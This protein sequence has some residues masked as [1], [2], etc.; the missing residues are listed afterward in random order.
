MKELLIFIATVFRDGF[1][2]ALR[3]GCPEHGLQASTGSVGG[4]PGGGGGPVERI[5][6]HTAWCG[7][8]DGRWWALIQRITQRLERTLAVF[9]QVWTAIGRLWVWSEGAGHDDYITI[10][11]QAPMRHFWGGTERPVGHL[12]RSSEGFVR[13]FWR[14]SERALHVWTPIRWLRGRAVDSHHVPRRL[15]ASIGRLGGRLEWV[16][17]C[18]RRHRGLIV[19]KPFIWPERFCRLSWRIGHQCV[20]WGLERISPRRLPGRWRWWYPI[21]Y[22]TGS[23]EGVHWVSLGLGGAVKGFKCCFSVCG[24]IDILI[25]MVTKIVSGVRRLFIKFR[26]WQRWGSNIDVRHHVPWGVGKGKTFAGLFLLAL[27]LCVHE[28]DHTEEHKAECTGRDNQEF[29]HLINGG[30]GHT[31]NMI[32]KIHKRMLQN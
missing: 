29:T 24:P 30:E 4:C 21:H 18:P 5:T 27:I 22:V 13:S 23:L 25:V 31:W 2:R 10:V 26:L 12:R 16:G 6:G 9:W 14:S 20:I 1:L 8:G 7:G 19:I 11:W 15:W 32:A 28:D 3:W 17:R